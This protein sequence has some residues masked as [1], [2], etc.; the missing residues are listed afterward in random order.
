MI[1]TFILL[2]AKA[3]PG[4]SSS[5]NSCNVVTCIGG[6]IGKGV[7]GAVGAVGNA[8]GGATN[9]V[10]GAVSG[11]ETFANFWSDPF[12]NTF[13]ALQS[14]AN[15]LASTVIPAFQKATLPDLSLNWFLKAYEVSFALGLMAAVLLLIPQFVRTARGQQSGREMAESLGLYLPLFLIGSMFGPAIGIFLTKFIGA[16]TDSLTSWAITGSSSSIT[17]QM[18]KML[19]AKDATGIAG[20]AVVGILFMILMILGLAIVMVMLVVQLVTLYFIGIAMP[21]GYLWIVDSNRRSFGMKVIGVWVS[22]LLSHPLLFFLLGVAYLML[23]SNVSVFSNSPT[24]KT[25]VTLC[26]S[27]IAMFFAGLSPLFLPKLINILPSGGSGSAPPMRA[28][29]IGPNSTAD[30]NKKYQD[31]SNDNSPS[32]I[33]SP[34]TTGGGP[35]MPGAVPGGAPR[36][37]NPVGGLANAASDEGN[38]GVHVGPSGRSMGAPAAEGAEGAAAE[39]GAAGGAAGAGTLAAEGAATA[40]TGGAAAAL[41]AAKE[42]ADGIKKTEANLEH[43]AESPVRDHEEHY[44]KDSLNG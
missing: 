25:T 28:S 36:T 13:K 7:S 33:G 29:S 34:A 24:L 31:T 6:A 14:G 18:T 26:V 3:T 11:A 8:V 42:V 35:S 17:Q 27:I 16:L 39:A 19:H 23:S 4:P 22:I 32:S 1:Q 44:G 21:L 5:A 43:A 12:G 38:G 37:D 10:G 40:G 9:A 20:G 41:I 30:A 15:G 2:A